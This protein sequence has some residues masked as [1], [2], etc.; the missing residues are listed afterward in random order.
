MATGRDMRRL[1]FQAL[2]QLDAHDGDHREDVRAAL[3][4]WEGFTPAERDRAYAEAVA[5]WEARAR[6]DET[7]ESLAPAWP[8][9]RQAAVDRA[10]LRLA[11]YQMHQPGALPKVVV[12]DAVELAKEFSTDRSPAFV[13]GLLDKVLKRVLAEGAGGGGT[14]LEAS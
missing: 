10:I 11:H 13:N 3:E 2:Y 1:A 5:A 4:Q 8:A 14:A 12:N 7:T 9:R 6:A